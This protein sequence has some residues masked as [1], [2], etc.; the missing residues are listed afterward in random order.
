MLCS[1]GLLPDIIQMSG[2]YDR[3]GSPGVNLCEPYEATLP[4]K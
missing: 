2:I 3:F 1:T 4:S